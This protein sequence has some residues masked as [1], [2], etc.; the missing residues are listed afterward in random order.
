MYRAA[1]KLKIRP[2]TPNLWPAFKDLFGENGACNGCW[3][4]YWRIGRAYGKRPRETNKAAFHEVVK[5]GPPPG[6]LAFHGDLA[7][8]WCQLTPRDAVPWLDRAWRLRRVDNVPVWS[9][10]CF[11]IRKGYRKRGVSSALIAAALKTANSA[12]APALEAYPLDADLTPSA[13][14]T[15]YATT[16]ARAGFRIVGRRTPPRP[17]MRRDFAASFNN[18]PSRNSIANKTKPK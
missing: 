10:T 15:G 11:Y 9:I 4:M 14:W 18:A 13:S 3:C 5:R 2:L 12:G 8:G 17:I 1:M 7:V 6:L 16:F